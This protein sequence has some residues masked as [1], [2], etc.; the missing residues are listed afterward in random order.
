MKRRTPPPAHDA[1]IADP[2]RRAD[3]PTLTPAGVVGVA[4]FAALC[5]GF[6]WLSPNAW[7][8]LLDSANLALHEAGHPL[9][10]LLSQ[11]ATVYGGTLF[12]LVFPL[13]AAWHFQRSGQVAGVAAA[14]VWLGENLLNIA[15]YMAD[16]RAQELPLVGSGDHDW[17]EIFTR[18]HVLHLDGR[19]AG[20]TR[21]LGVLLIVAAVV[22]LVR[23]LLP[24]TD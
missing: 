15:R 17:T 5:L 11:R 3:Q 10:S 9:L 23:K 19:I 13:T 18:W 4:L 7:V 24:P 2:R 12:Q 20:L 22:W 14:I 16:A 21:L 8:P 6:H 1:T